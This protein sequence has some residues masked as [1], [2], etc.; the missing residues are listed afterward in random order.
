[1]GPAEIGILATIVAA[2]FFVWG[3][4]RA[5]R[6]RAER[7]RPPW[8]ISPAGWGAI[9]V[10]LL[11]VA[12]ILYFGA[13]RTTVVSDPSLAHREDTVIADTPE[14]RAKLLK[15]AGELPLL[16]PPQPDTRGWHP[17]PLAQRDFRFFDGQLWTREVT[18]NPAQRI[19]AAVG[20]EKADLGRR[21]RTAPPPADASPSWHL[22]P[23]GEH[24]FRYFDGEAW[25]AEVREAR[26]S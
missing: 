25:T 23:L 14:E 17:D 21:L 24:H 9:H 26:S 6:F 20:D 13:S 7:G 4:A 8:G 3:W 12:W 19:A 10:V 18:D 16:R 5:A 2:V 15:I 1:V 11:P 22:D